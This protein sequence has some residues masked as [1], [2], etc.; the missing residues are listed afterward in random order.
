MIFDTP[1]YENLS[2][3]Y[4]D[5]IYY[6]LLQ[7]TYNGIIAQLH[8]ICDEKTQDAHHQGKC[9]PEPIPTITIDFYTLYFNF[10]IRETITKNWEKIFSPIEI[11]LHYFYDIHKEYYKEFELDEYPEHPTHPSNKNYITLQLYSTS[12]EENLDNH[13]TVFS[14][15][16]GQIPTQVSSENI[17][18]PGH[19]A[20]VMDIRFPNGSTSNPG[21]Q[22]G[23]QEARP[24]WNTNSGSQTYTPP[25]S[26]EK[27][28]YMNKIKNRIVLDTRKLFAMDFQDNYKS[29]ISDYQNKRS[30]INE[31]PFPPPSLNLPSHILSIFKHLPPNS[32][33]FYNYVANKTTRNYFLEAMTISNIML[34]L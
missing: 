18:C 9:L 33:Y 7:K 8:H 16:Y 28:I 5:Y 1:I 19:S 3:E 23:T 22:V 30:E 4:I 20:S 15:K 6:Y 25:E 11:E 13:N 31:T 34:W 32:I 10:T 24:Y 17:V 14:I 26:R 21:L 27:N 29:D 12:I 2:Y